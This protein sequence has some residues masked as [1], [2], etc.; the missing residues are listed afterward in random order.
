MAYRRS[1]LLTCVKAFVNREFTSKYSG[2][3]R[4]AVG[5]DA[6]EVRDTHVLNAWQTWTRRGAWVVW[7]SSVDCVEGLLS[8][9]LRSS[10]VLRDCV[11]RGT[12]SGRC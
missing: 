5:T 9:G 8:E 12:G 1:D 10:Y 6:L 11:G 4:G 3:L 7:V 2:E